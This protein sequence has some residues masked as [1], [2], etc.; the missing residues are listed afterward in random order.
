MIPKAHARG[1]VIINVVHDA[2]PLPTAPFI[3][4]EGNT[5]WPLRGAEPRM[6]LNSRI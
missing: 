1:F 4:V 5:S 3:V 2:R 6:M